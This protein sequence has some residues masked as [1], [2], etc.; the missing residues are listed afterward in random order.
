MK[1]VVVDIS[2]CF[3]LASAYAA[4]AFVRS[5]F[6]PRG[7]FGPSHF[8]PAARYLVAAIRRG[9]VSPSLVGDEQ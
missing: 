7:S 4:G 5:H 1:N 6:G 9:D 2:S 8:V 3:L